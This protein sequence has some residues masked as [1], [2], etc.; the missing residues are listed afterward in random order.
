MSSEQDRLAL[1]SFLNTLGGF[2]PLRMDLVGIT[3]RVLLIMESGGC[4]KPSSSVSVSSVFLEKT[5]LYNLKFLNVMGNLQTRS[6]HEKAMR[7]PDFADEIIS[8]VVRD[9]ELGD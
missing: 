4:T 7:T 8:V 1:D 2:A 5:L 6:F 3:E 9:P